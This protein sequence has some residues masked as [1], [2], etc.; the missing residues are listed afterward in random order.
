MGHFNTVYVLQNWYGKFYAA[1][2]LMWF[3]DYTLN[4]KFSEVPIYNM[5]YRTA[6]EAYLGHY[7]ESMMELFCDNS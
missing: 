4:S 1:Q 6:T 5:L 7:Q 2:Y 3:I